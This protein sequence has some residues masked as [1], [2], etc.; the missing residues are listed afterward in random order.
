MIPLNCTRFLPV[1]TDWGTCYAI[2]AASMAAVFDDPEFVQ[3]LHSAHGVTEASYT[4][5]NNRDCAFMKGPR[6]NRLVILTMV[7]LNG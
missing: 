7:T 6:F 4:I 3:G 1:A 2:N 5:A